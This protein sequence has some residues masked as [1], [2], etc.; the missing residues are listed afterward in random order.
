MRTFSGSRTVL[1]GQWALPGGFVDEGEPLNDAAA[2]ELQ[3]ETSVNPRDVL[4]EQVRV[5]EQHLCVSH[6]PSQAWRLPSCKRGPA[7]S[8]MR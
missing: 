2:R 5:Q 4:L 3:E 6:T 8:L 1:Q 7:L